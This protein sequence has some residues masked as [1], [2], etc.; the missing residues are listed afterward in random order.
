M[1]NQTKEL[2]SRLTSESCP[3]I[4]Y[5]ILAGLVLSGCCQYPQ[6]YK[7]GNYDSNSEKTLTIYANNELVIEE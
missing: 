1:F 2:K 7:I 5:V 3:K 4:Q 6:I